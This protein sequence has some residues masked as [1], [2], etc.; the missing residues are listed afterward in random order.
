MNNEKM[1]ENQTILLY[2]NNNIV[3]ITII[4]PTYKR[5]KMLKEAL[6]SCLNQKTLQLKYNILIIDNNAE[7]MDEENYIHI[8]SLNNEKII[9]Y[10]NTK[11][12][13]AIG[14]FNRGIELAKGNYIIFLHDDDIFEENYLI[15]I[16]KILLMKKKIELLSIEPFIEDLR[17]INNKRPKIFFKNFF[18]KKLYKLELE[19]FI[20]GNPI[21]FPGAVILRKK[22]LELGGFS[23]KDGPITDYLFWIKFIKGKEVYKYKKRLIKYRILENDSLNIE[24][25]I[26]IWMN[27]Y[28]FRK[29]QLEN[30]FKSKK[31]ARELSKCLLKSEIE[32]SFLNDNNKKI[33][34]HKLKL[35][36]DKISLIYK[37][38]I[39]L[40]NCY[41][42]YFKI[43]IRMERI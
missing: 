31:I 3:D 12:L 17:I 35:N 38:I 23:E 43:L 29:K 14:N 34:K 24:T 8:K 28:E 40:Y 2:G 22:A 21:C 41:Y 33:A 27:S 11:N 39:K 4:I 32:N 42:N 6:K 26:K 15:E 30:K 10:K 19:N 1:K 18:K 9:Y 7:I 13:G 16:E 37:I 36:L 5:E 20:S 25:N